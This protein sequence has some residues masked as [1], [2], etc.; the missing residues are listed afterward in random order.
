MA[1]MNWDIQREEISSFA[2]TLGLQESILAAHP[3]LLPPVTF[4]RGSREG[5]SLIDGIWMSAN[6]QASAV[7]LCPV[8]LSPGDHQAAL[9]DI[10]LML[11]I[12]EP[13]LTVVRPKAQRLNTQLPQTKA[14]YLAL[15]EEHFLSH[16]FSHSCFNYTRMSLIPALTT[17]LLAPI[18][19]NWTSSML[20][21]CTLLKNTAASSTWELL[22]TL[23]PSHYGL[24]GKY[25]GVW[26]LRNYLMDMLPPIASD[27]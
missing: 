1:D 14:R 2:A 16:C 13:R 21:E 5:C 18:S 24:T 22:P 23:L 19:R 12:R 8:S 3:T 17:H 27:A 4:K 25:Y 7:S 9:L 6:L 20:Q 15:L 10:D 11:L 26:L